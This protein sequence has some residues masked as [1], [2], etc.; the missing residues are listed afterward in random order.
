MKQTI[1]IVKGETTGG[2]D[3]HFHGIVPDGTTEWQM[4]DGP[5][6]KRGS[7]SDFLSLIEA[8]EA[9]PDA[10]FNTDE[11]DFTTAE[12]RIFDYIVGQREFA[13]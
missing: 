6:G 2:E 10:N 5:A 11:A 13:A 4:S 9:F 8:L 12:W 7:S 1:F 3:G